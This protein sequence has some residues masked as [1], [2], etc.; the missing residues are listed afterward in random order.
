[1][2]IK[3]IGTEEEYNRALAEVEPYF[4][5]VPAK[6]SPEAERFDT[7]SNLISAFEEEN[8]PV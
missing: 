3:S 6:G 7:L 1:M 5:N 2:D 8:Y 4:D